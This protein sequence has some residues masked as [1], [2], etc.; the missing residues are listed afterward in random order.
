VGAADGADTSGSGA[1]GMRMMMVTVVPP[2]VRRITTVSP[3]G[4]A[5][6]SS[7]IPSSRGSALRAAVAAAARHLSRAGRRFLRDAVRAGGAPG[8]LEAAPHGD[9]YGTGGRRGAAVSAG[10][11]DIPEDLRRA[12]ETLRAAIG[13]AAQGDPRP[14]QA[15][16]SHR[17]DVTA[18]Y[19][20]GGYE[21]GWTAVRERW[22]W[23][24]SQ[25]GGG[26]V[27]YENLTTVVTPELAYT[28][29]V[30]TFRVRLAA[31]GREAAWSNRVTHILRREDGAWRLVHRH[32]NRLEARV[33]AADRLRSRLPPRPEP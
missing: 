27:S 23:A 1:P 26:T 19:G 14:I 20:W 22:A 15:L 4:H 32:A 10:A 31:D 18:F 8:G 7:T 9:A 28:T 30:E 29:D 25:F 17:D 11:A 6:A 16:Y 5:A 2:G 3:P 21:R 24:A 12:I 33:P 13:R